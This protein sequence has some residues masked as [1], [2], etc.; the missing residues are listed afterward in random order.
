MKLHEI[1]KNSPLRV[2]MEDGSIDLAEFCHCDGMYSLCLTS[3][4]KTFHLSRFTPMKL[5][6]GRYEIN[7][8]IKEL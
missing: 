2:E 6:D 1:P 8:E 5:V 4:K 7:K 3:D